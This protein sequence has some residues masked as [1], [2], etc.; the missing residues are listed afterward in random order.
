MTFSLSLSSLHSFHRGV[1]AAVLT[2]ALARTSACDLCSA[3]S[4]DDAFGIARPG[5]S[6][7]AATQFT[8]F[9][10]LR[11]EGRKVFDPAAQRLDSAIT[12]AVASYRFNDRFAAQLN[13]PFIHRSFRRPDGFAIDRGHES[14]LGDASLIGRWTALRRD[15]EKISFGLNLLA[16]LKFATGSA[17]R[18]AEEFSETEI[19]GAPA[20]GVHGHDL[21]LGTGSTDALGGAQLFVRAGR[22]FA[23]A[24]LQYT[25][26]RTGR[27]DY[28]FAND[29]TWEFASG[30]HV[31]VASDGT[32]ALQAVVSGEHKGMDTFAGARA[33]DTGLTA[34][35]AGP[36]LTYTRAAKLNAELGVD[37]PVRIDN[38]ALQLTP[39]YKLRA[40]VTW[41]F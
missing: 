34:I 18:I 1:F 40:S 26:R 23:T 14:G 15:S 33:D 6:F 24:S 41:G 30:V 22:A 39:D 27:Y 25:A 4:E 10:T 12:Q 38:T 7:S 3:Y 17:H 20:S 35:Y 21:T 32:L 36:R 5:W 8:H 19:P 11:N 9:A 16:G 37:L 29:L 2:L 13:V 28:R 31:D